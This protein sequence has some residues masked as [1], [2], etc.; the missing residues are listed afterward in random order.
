MERNING[1]DG[2]WSKLV[3]YAKQGN[4]L[5]NTSFTFNHQV[6]FASLFPTLC[7]DFLHVFPLVFGIIGFNSIGVKCDNPIRKQ[8]VIDFH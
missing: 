6:V 5:A 7:N 1:R 3:G 4:G 8:I 2:K